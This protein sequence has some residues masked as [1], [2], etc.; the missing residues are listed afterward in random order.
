MH[1]TL[2]FFFST[3]IGVCK[4]DA[5]AFSWTAKAAAEGHDSAQFNLGEFRS[6]RK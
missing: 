3:G 2:G 6:A 4:N 5:D 1:V